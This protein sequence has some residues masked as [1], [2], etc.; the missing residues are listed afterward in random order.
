MAKKKSSHASPQSLGGQARAKKLDEASRSQ[1]ARAAAKKRWSVPKA[2]FQ[3][4]LDIGAVQLPC[5]VLSDGRRVLSHRGLQAGMTMTVSGGVD[6]TADFFGK[7]ENELAVPKSLSEKLSK[8][9]EFFPQKSGRTAYGFEADVLAEICDLMLEARKRLKNMSPMQVRVANQCEIL[10]RGFAK[11]GIIALVDEATG[12]QKVRARNALAEI[13]EAFIQD[14][15]G[16]WA[17]RFPDEFY[18][19][20]FRLKG[21]AWP[22]PKNPPQYVGHW[23]NNLIYR[24]LAPGVLDDLR[25]KNPRD[26]S[27]NRRT[28]HH[29]WLTE[30]IGHPKLQEHIQAVIALMRAS[31]SWEQF[32]S[33]LDRALPKQPRLAD[34][35]Q[36][37]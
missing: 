30:D 32:Q 33:M 19:E 16:K 8:P 18:K 24:R 21:K 20:L 13:L 9:I 26:A 4:T 22:F 27:G 6:K 7:L 15:A 23:T 5:Y 12:Y 2:E 29:Q 17:K 10:L 28:R 37:E 14:E 1:I 25:R 3:G 35:R 11:V 34:A 31:D 36:G